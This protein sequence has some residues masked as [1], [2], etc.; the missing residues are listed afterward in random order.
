MK[1]EKIKAIPFWVF[2]ITISI[3]MNSCSARK[4]EKN[5]STEETKTEV[6]TESDIAKKEESSSNVDQQTTVVEKE[7][8]R[9]VET[10]YKPI[11]AT[12]EATV[13]TPEGKKHIL[14]NAKVVIKETTQDKETKTDTSINSETTN[15]S[16]LT[17]KSKAD[18]KA[19]VKK[20]S[21]AILIDRKETNP[22][23]LLWWLIP[24]FIII[25]VLKKQSKIANWISWPWWV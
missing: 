10:T 4:A 19:D 15:K 2:V 1:N 24:I 22:L 21:E 12:K 18:N 3:L 11:D 9:E 20:S 8:V 16:E 25:F 13:T 14:N 23:N 5:R 7:K 6:A 17:D